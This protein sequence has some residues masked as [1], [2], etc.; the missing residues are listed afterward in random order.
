MFHL[1]CL[2]CYRMLYI[3]LHFV[4]FYSLPYL[5]IF[6]ISTYFMKTDVMIKST[7]KIEWLIVVP[8]CII[9]GEVSRHRQL[10]RKIGTHTGSSH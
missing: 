9:N 8:R 7:S 10:E 5:F 4:A 6:I 2:F 3:N 1:K